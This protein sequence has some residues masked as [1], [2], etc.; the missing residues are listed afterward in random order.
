[1]PVAP[2]LHRTDTCQNR[3][4]CLGGKGRY[5]EDWGVWRVGVLGIPV[6]MAAAAVAVL[7]GI[8]AVRTWRRS[9]RW[10]VLAGS[11]VLAEAAFLTVGAAAANHQLQVFGTWADVIGARPAGAYRE[12]P[13][14]GLL[15]PKMRRAAVA[16]NSLVRI[17]TG[18]QSAFGCGVAQ[19]PHEY[20]AERR[21]LRQYPVVVI[22]G[23]VSRSSIRI[24]PLAGVIVVRACGADNGH[25]SVSRPDRTRLHHAFRSFAS[26]RGWA[27]IGTGSDAWT[28]LAVGLQRPSDYAVVG[29]VDPDPSTAA[30]A[31][32]ALPTGGCEIQ[33]VVAGENVGTPAERAIWARLRHASC[34]VTVLP[35]AGAGVVQAVAALLPAPLAAPNRV[36]S[37]S[38]TNRE[39]RTR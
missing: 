21:N 30:Q 39:S 10:T 12:K 19:V 28:Q 35:A 17:D 34:G 7:V 18:R 29:L 36:R 1:M 2:L 11:L 24:D 32:A 8:Y 27:L 31:L 4:C 9:K 33:V 26:D 37:V 14:R 16:G 22:A 20:T 23:P 25:G 6:L 13:P 38:L 5:P 3:Q 15:D